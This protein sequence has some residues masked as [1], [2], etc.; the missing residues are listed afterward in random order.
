[1]VADSPTMGDIQKELQQ[2][3][4]GRI[5]VSHGAFDRNALKHVLFNHQWLNSMKIIR[6]AYPEKYGKRGYRLANL[7]K[8]FGI[9]LKHHDALEDAKATADILLEILDDTKTTIDYWVD[10]V[11]EPITPYK[12]KAYK[13]K[14]GTSAPP[15]KLQGIEDGPLS[16]HTVVFTGELAMTRKE[17]AEKASAEG[18]NV[19]PGVTKRTTM[20]VV[21]TQKSRMIAPG[22]KSS[23]H[24]KAEKYIEKGQE[25]EILTEENFLQLIEMGKTRLGYDE[26]GFN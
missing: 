13:R 10:R 15:I 11:K 25:I 3:L 20:L 7:A 16:G 9:T 4:D 14:A 26:A 18:C 22:D 5:I 19:E 8:D 21:G 6:R 12:R 23:K 24:K 17:S 1:M 2:Q